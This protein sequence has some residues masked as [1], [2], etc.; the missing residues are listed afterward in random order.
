MNLS[1]KKQSMSYAE[2]LARMTGTSLALTGAKGEPSPENKT[3]KTQV[4]QT[5]GLHAVSVEGGEV[6]LVRRAREAAAAMLP[7]AAQDRQASV[8]KSMAPLRWCS[9]PIS[10]RRSDGCVVAYSRAKSSI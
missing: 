5:A 10:G 9:I 4:R 2:A 6:Q 3:K 8:R 1:Q 7:S